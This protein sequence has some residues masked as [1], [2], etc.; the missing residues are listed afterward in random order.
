MVSWIILGAIA[1]G[2]T[3]RYFANRTLD[4][5]PESSARIAAVKRRLYVAKLRKALE[6]AE[7]D[8]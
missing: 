5:D 8:G 1:G 4:W 7:N 2:A 6:N 3:G